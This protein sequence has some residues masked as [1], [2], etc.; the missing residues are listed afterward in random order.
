MHQFVDLMGVAHLGER[1]TNK[2]K[3]INLEK[4]F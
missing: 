1:G 4:F 3:P 2:K